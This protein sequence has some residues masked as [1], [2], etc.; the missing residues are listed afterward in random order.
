MAKLRL[1]L[2]SDEDNSTR[3]FLKQAVVYRRGHK[4]WLA[5]VVFRQLSTQCDDGGKLLMKLSV[6]LRVQHSTVT[7]T[8]GQDIYDNLTNYRHQS[9]WGI[10]IRH[11]SVGVEEVDVTL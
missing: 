9:P 7:V 3:R 6:W 1:L 5:L 8:D 11:K 4:F 10:K 2:S